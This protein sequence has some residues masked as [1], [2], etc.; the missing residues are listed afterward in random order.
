MSERV[1]AEQIEQIVGIQRH[2]TEHFARAVSAERVVY[3]LH[4]HECRDS[5]PDLRTCPFSLALDRGIECRGMVPTWQ[6]VL[7]RPVRVDVFSG[8]LV[9]DIRGTS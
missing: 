8:R 1:P 6:G 7:D 9:P 5:T 4:S 3:V 2:Q